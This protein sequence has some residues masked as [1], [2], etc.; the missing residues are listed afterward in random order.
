MLGPLRTINLAQR[1]ENL[2]AEVQMLAPP[3][4]DKMPRRQM[5]HAGRPGG[6]IRPR[7]ELPKLTPQHHRRLLVNVLGVRSVLYEGV[8]K[9]EQ[10]AMAFAQQIREQIGPLRWPIDFIR[11]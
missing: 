10:I 3:R 4:A 11:R 8:D 6:E 1:I 7:R 9:Y 2:V 5:G